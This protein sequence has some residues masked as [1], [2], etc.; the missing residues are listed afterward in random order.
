MTQQPSTAQL[1]VCQGWCH[2]EPNLYQPLS[3][4]GQTRS[5]IVS[6]WGEHNMSFTHSCSSFYNTL[7]EVRVDS[8]CCQTLRSQQQC[9]TNLSQKLSRQQKLPFSR[10]NCHSTQTLN[11][12]LKLSFRQK[13]PFTVQTV[14]SGRNCSFRCKLSHQFLLFPKFLVAEFCSAQVIR[15]VRPRSICETFHPTETHICGF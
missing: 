10:T 1:V 15:D 4:G 9:K 12:S 7:G 8:Q 2:A 6:V 14:T 11:W 13:L 5:M 3:S